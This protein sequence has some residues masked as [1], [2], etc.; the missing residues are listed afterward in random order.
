MFAEKTEAVWRPA[1]S[2]SPAK[3]ETAAAE[4]VGQWPEHELS[5]RRT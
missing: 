2:A 3:H 1:L 5:H 4:A